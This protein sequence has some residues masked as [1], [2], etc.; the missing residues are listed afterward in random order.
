MSGP[1]RPR[2]ARD[3]AETAV[4]LHD[5]ATA[6]HTAHEKAYGPGIIGIGNTTALQHIHALY[7]GAHAAAATAAAIAALDPH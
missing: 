3:W 5:K 6:L 7:A 4:Q 2:T 1:A